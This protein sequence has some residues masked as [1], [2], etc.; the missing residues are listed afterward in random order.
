[1]KTWKLRMCVLRQPL[2]ST[3]GTT[4]L[5]ISFWRKFSSTS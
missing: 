2:C 1:M 5:W 3:Y 4:L